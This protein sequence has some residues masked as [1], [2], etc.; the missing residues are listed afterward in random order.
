MAQAQIS[1][2]DK[3]GSFA[4]QPTRSASDRA[5]TLVELAVVLAMITVLA[6]LILPAM[7]ATHD[8]SNR[9]I[10]QYHLRQIAIT[11]TEDAADNNDTLVSAAS[12]S[13]GSTGSSFP[14]AL[15]ASAITAAQIG[16]KTNLNANN[17]WT[18]PNRPGL[19]VKS[20]TTLWYIGYQYFGGITTWSP[21]IIDSIPS[22]SPVKMS[23]AKPYWT[24]AADSLLKTSG[25]WA[26]QVVTSGDPFYFEYSN[27]PSHHTTDANIPQGGNQVFCD[28]SVQ[29]IDLEKTYR[30]TSFAGAIGTVDCYFYQDPVDFS[31]HLRALLPILAATP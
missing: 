20:G 27:I 15:N 29:W 22:R 9:A 8:R 17:I 18:C 28:G 1:P 6:V 12:F 11:V 30:L 26:G 13:F 23:Q 2:V 3:S 4:P 21:P 10:C 24:L 14:D 25:R 19:P 16:L 7:A 5:F 31:S